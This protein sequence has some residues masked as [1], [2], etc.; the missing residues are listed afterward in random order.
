[1]TSQEPE[2]QQ[3]AERDIPDTEVISV[4]APAPVFV[5]S[6]GRRSRLLR[7]LAYAF[8]AMVVLYGALISVSVAGGPVPS[9]A[10]LPLPGLEPPATKAAQPSPTPAPTPSHSPTAVFL[11][12]ALPHLTTAPRTSTPRLESTRVTS[13]P[14]TTTKPVRKPT[15]ATPKPSTT[16]TR[17][18]ESTTTPGTTTPTAGPTTTLG[19]VPPETG[20]GTGTGGQGGGSSSGS[21][22]T[23][24]V[25]PSKAGDPAAE[26]TA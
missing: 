14:A 1:V 8:G 24:P 3:F 20:T 11:A 22:T 18:T 23:A 6:T 19:P 9:S 13:K 5:D 21:G 16:T 15:T 26:V 7:R 17:P 4:A 10:A 12:G 2:N 25:T